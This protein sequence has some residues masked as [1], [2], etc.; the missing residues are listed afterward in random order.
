MWVEETLTGTSFS[1]QGDSA[2]FLMENG[3]VEIKFA[4]AG[5]TDMPKKIVRMKD[6][7]IKLNNQIVSASSID[8]NDWQF[9]QTV[10]VKLTAL[11]ES[12][13]LVDPSPEMFPAIFGRRT[14][15]NGDTPTRSDFTLTTNF[16]SLVDRSPESVQSLRLVKAREIHVDGLGVA[17]RLPS[18]E[19]VIE[20]YDRTK[21]AVEAPLAGKPNE[22]CFVDRQGV[23][24]SYP[25]GSSIPI[26]VRQRLGHLPRVIDLLK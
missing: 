10:A 12:I 13:C 11:E 5:V 15:A 7:T 19:I 8:V 17:K 9:L 18:G 16:T 23:K 25:E 14:N 3:D 4:G 21:V 24:T 22:F 20:F 1:L 26:H 6:G 2:C